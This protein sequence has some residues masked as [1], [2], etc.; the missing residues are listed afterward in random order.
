MRLSVSYRDHVLAITLNV[1]SLHIFPG[2]LVEEV[3]EIKILF[4]D[5]TCQRPYSI[6]QCN[7]GSLVRGPAKRVSERAVALDK[8]QM[9]SALEQ[10][11]SY[12]FM[13][14]RYLYLWIIG[15]DGWTFSK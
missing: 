10:M 11:S 15:T 12:R 8:P 4:C 3:L 7:W 1:V 13:A 6:P 14:A 9:G 2:S 5:G